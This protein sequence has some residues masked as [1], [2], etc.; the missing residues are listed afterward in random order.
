[1]TKGVEDVYIQRP[2]A[3]GVGEVAFLYEVL[4][5]LF[6]PDRSIVRVRLFMRYAVLRT[7]LSGIPE[8]LFAVALK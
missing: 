6:G 8:Y 7:W 2:A 1:M 4:K 3:G 5:H